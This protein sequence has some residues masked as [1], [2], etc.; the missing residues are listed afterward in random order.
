MKEQKQITD[1]E[2]IR[3]MVDSFYHKVRED[4]LL[5]PIF[6]QRIGNKWPEH[7][8]KMYR[9]WGT[10]L[11]GEHTYLGSPFL[12]HAK[13]PLRKQHFDRWLELFYQT[14]DEHFKGEKAREA[15]WRAEKMAEMFY[16]KIQFIQNNPSQSV[17]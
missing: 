7:L 11:L 16:H 10:V 3:L 13:M 5:G 1:S 6:N 2:H 14:I 17:L 4:A 8:E 12:P 15:R 9:F